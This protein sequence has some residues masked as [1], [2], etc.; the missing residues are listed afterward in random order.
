M[1]QIKSLHAQI[2]LRGLSDDAMSLSKL[3][4]FC[5]L[6][7]SGDL[8]YAYHMF[9]KIPQRNRHMY[10]TL[11]RA[12]SNSK[13]AE[14]AIFLY[15]RMV[16]SGII[17]NEFTFPFILKACAFRKAYIEGVSVHL[18]AVKLGF[19]EFYVCVQNGFINF[20]VG[21]GQ[22]D[23]ARKI[24]DYTE[25]RTLVSW[26]SM[27]GG[28]AKMGC[29]REA[30][31]LFS[32]M[33]E[34]GVD[35]DGHTFVNL[36]SVSSRIYDIE[37]GRCVH[38]Y[39]EINGIVVDIYVQNALLDM[40]AKCGHL[41]MAKAVFARMV[42]KNVV[43]W[44]SMLNAYAKHGFVEL[45]ERIFNEMPVKNVVSWNSMISCYLQSGYYRESLDLFYRMCE[46]CM[47]PDETTMVSV[48]SACS[49]LSDLVTGKKL[50]DY[51]RDNSVKPTI[52]LFNSLIDMYA[53]C[54]SAET[55]LDV[56]MNMPEKNIVSWN[57]IINALALHGYGNIAV[58]LFHEMEGCRFRPDGV[59]FSGL[60]SACCHC[61][62]VETGRYIFNKMWDMYKIPYDIEHYACMIDILGRGGLLNEAVKVVG[63]M[64]MKPDI[65]IWGTL[66]AACRIYRN[67]PIAKMVLKQLLEMEPHT[68]GLY[69][70]MSN[71]F[72][73]AQLWDE[74]K[75]M[76]KLMKDFGVRKID[77]VSSIEVGGCVFEFMV[78]DKKHEA[79]NVI[80]TVLYQLKDHL[81]KKK[82]TMTEIS[83]TMAINDLSAISSTMV[84]QNNQ[85]PP[86]RW[87]RHWLELE[88]YK[89]KCKK[90][91]NKYKTVF[92]CACMGKPVCES[93]WKDSKEE[94]LCHP[95]LQV[96][97]NSLIKFFAPFIF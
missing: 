5:A 14:K 61:G 1:D 12:C 83:S 40:Y 73:E 85:N 28:Y 35:P 43:S 82:N 67:V 17:P 4:S 41:Q 16:C 9:D 89:D 49:Q 46:S 18:H 33:R 72:C 54:G 95:C 23:C 96:S 81:R 36:L 94:H 53:K 50:H 91:L 19:S 32:E 44:T 97:E 55:A 42:D 51:I 6:S 7:S 22:I 90:H 20:Y 10:N 39:I 76:R 86:P 45:A 64:A 37:L 29:G 92:C 62:L 71:I 21:C 56:F 59:T 38:W 74:M 13:Q 58:E 25:F 47:A 87:L 52:T 78:D 2:I 31:S 48:L 3:I 75:K 15:K 70:L 34:G 63:K 60:L 84:I 69:V 26:N 24:F 27:M 11:I 8:Q 68:G 65:V 57:T 77:A 79:S 66:L 80:Y 30:F 93:C 88:F